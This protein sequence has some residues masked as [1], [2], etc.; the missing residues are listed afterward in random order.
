[1]AAL[2]RGEKE[3]ECHEAVFDASRLASGVYL[4]RFAVG[5]FVETKKLLLLR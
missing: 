1:V 4:C 3:A 2:A 5:S